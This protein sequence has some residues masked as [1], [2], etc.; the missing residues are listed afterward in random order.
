M[1]AF[2]WSKMKIP[3]DFVDLQMSI[4][5]TSF[6]F[7]LFH[8]LDKTFPFALYTVDHHIRED[9]YLMANVNSE[10]YNEKNTLSLV[11]KIS[12][13]LTSAFAQHHLS[14][15]STTILMNF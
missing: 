1:N 11:I 9:N 8:S 4:Y 14:L 7:F 3:G 6:T 10:S 13:I 12:Q 15:Q 5:I 2:P